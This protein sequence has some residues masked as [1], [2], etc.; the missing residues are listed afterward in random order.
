MTTAAA[1][2]ATQGPKQMLLAAGSPLALSKVDPGQPVLNTLFDPGQAVLALSLHRCMSALRKQ[3]RSF[4]VP[5]TFAPH[6]AA[7]EA[8]L[9]DKKRSCFD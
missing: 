3:N 8:I 7:L 9:P 6:N 1:T 2:C 5:A 4:R